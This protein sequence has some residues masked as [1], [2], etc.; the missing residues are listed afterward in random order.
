[1]ASYILTFQSMVLTASS[2][3]KSEQLRRVYQLQMSLISTCD[4]LDIGVMKQKTEFQMTNNAMERA[5]TFLYVIEDL[6]VVRDSYSFGED[7]ILPSAGK[8]VLFLDVDW[9][10]SVTRS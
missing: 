2:S 4:R 1:M 8:L 7:A 5:R 3:N 10:H 6:I 9:T